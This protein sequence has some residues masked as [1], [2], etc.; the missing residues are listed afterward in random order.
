MFARLVLEALRHLDAGF[1]I[2]I[3][4]SL[5]LMVTHANKLFGII[6]PQSGTFFD[7]HNLLSLHRGLLHSNSQKRQCPSI[8][9]M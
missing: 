3:V 1:D 8:Y 4:A 9:T 7:E 2:C 6:V 5:I